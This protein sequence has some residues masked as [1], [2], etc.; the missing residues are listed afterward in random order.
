MCGA[1]PRR[2]SPARST[3]FSRRSRSCSRNRPRSPAW[4]RS[5]RRAQRGAP[6][7]A[8]PE[9]KRALNRQERERSQ[10][11]LLDLSLDWLQFAAEPA[12]SA[13]EKWVLFLSDVYVVASEKVRLAPLIYWHFELI[14]REA[15]GR[16]PS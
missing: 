8:P 6:A 14:A 13:F 11:A 5:C 4:R 10:A 15:L 2:G 7:R 16:R 3:A 1:R 9:E 12:N